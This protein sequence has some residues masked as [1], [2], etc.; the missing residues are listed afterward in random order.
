MAQNLDELNWYKLSLLKIADDIG[1]PKAES[2]NQIK[3][4]LRRSFGISLDRDS[5][6][7]IESIIKST[8]ANSAER[9]EKISSFLFE[10]EF[11]QAD[12]S[13]MTAILAPYE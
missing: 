11:K 7:K 3:R 12:I 5:A 6:Q 13:V 9:M 4:I 1:T 2:G 10:S 8:K